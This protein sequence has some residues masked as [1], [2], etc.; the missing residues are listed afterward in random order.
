MKIR[1]IIIFNIIGVAKLKRRLKKTPN[2]SNASL[3]CAAGKMLVIPILEDYGFV[4]TGCE[5]Y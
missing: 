1:F 3:S 2:T 4:P 5:Y